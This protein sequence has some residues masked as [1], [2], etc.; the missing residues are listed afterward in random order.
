MAADQ[1]LLDIISN[2]LANASTN[3]F[4]ADGVTFANAME[5]QLV[6]GGTSIGTMG[7]GS[8]EQNAF[9][10]FTP[11]S[12]MIT[13]NPLDVAIS[14][15]KGLF[16]VQIDPNTIAYTRDGSFELN[17]NRQLV[18]K[19]GYAVLDSSRQPIQVGDGPIQ[20]GTDGSVSAGGVTAGKIGVFDGTFTKLGENLFSA[21]STNSI[22]A[23]LQPNALESS[24]VNAIQAMIQMITLNRSF[25]LA[26]KSVIQQDGLTQTL[27]QSLSA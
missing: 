14:S 2:N 9:T 4:K 25:E 17:A 8:T 6:S 20:I 23:P 10:D 1:R 13:N 18:T 15:A 7:T 22:Q 5:Q 21:D 3:G 16:A 26:Q 12:V 24:N 27:I 11:G 19:Q